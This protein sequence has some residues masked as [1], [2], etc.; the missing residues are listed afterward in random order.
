MSDDFTRRAELTAALD[1]ATEAVRVFRVVRFRAQTASHLLGG[2]ATGVGGV[3]FDALTS[4]DDGDSGD[5]D[6]QRPRG[7]AVL[8]LDAA[9]QPAWRFSFHPMQPDLEAFVMEEVVRAAR[10][11]GAAIEL[12]AEQ[13]GLERWEPSALTP[14]ASPAT[15]GAFRENAAPSVSAFEGVGLV[16]SREGDVL[17]LVYERK[18][19]PSLLV[20]GLAVAFGIAFWWTIPIALV[21][22]A[23]RKALGEVLRSALRGHTFRWEATLTPTALEVREICD[24]VVGE[25]AQVDRRGRVLASWAP[26]GWTSA[27]VTGNDGR[28]LRGYVFRVLGPEGFVFVPL[29]RDLQ[30]ELGPALRSALSSG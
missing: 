21:L 8:A 20:A 29:P 26:S 3:I 25:R 9:G 2:L 14:A 4:G 1:G 6:D 18:T 30:R 16:A 12:F 10:R 22:R 19:R 17:R 27:Q 28:T 23:G 11:L 5:A 15:Q 7:L 24:G 13:T